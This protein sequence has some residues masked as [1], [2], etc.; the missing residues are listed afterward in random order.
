MKYCRTNKQKGSNRHYES[1]KLIGPGATA[2]RQQLAV[3]EVDGR[4][5]AHALSLLQQRGAS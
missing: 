1:M 4:A 3:F 2:Q 5:D